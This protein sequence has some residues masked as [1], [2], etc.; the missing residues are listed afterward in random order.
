[1]L[2]F[3][4]MSR[5]GM[6]ALALAGGLGVVGSGLTSAQDATPEMPAVVCS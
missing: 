3:G 4:T 2:Q 6:L 1:M 5:R